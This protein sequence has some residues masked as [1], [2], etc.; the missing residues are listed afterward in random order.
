MAATD[1]LGRVGRLLPPLMVLVC[2]AGAGAAAGETAYLG[3]FGKWEAR[4]YTDPDGSRQCA[5]RAIH[6]DLVDGDILWVFNTGARERMPHGYLAVDRRLAGDALGAAVA[7][8]DGQLFPLQRG[9][10]LHFYN[11]AADA[12]A[13]LAGFQRGYTATVRL[14]GADGGGEIRLSLI[15]FTRAVAA[16]REACG[17]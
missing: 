8:D 17:F 15:G 3:L 10:D 16:A 9:N 7:L 6:P 11:S 13:I 14:E 2:I 5:V 4:E 12:E 1:L